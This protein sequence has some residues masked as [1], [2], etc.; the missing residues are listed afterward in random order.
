MGNFSLF[1]P[2]T[3]LTF[4]RETDS[5]CFNGEGFL[6]SRTMVICYCLPTDFRIALRKTCEMKLTFLLKRQKVVDF[7]I[8]LFLA[9]R[10]M[11]SANNF[12]T[13]FQF[14]SDERKLIAP[15]KRFC[16]IRNFFI[17]TFLLLNSIKVGEK[18]MN[19]GYY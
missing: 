18:I 11:Q 3:L 13:I 12:W 17:G 1:Y 2:S 7:D 15:R 6:F 16:S 19:K 4:W 14:H 5:F 8:V 10:Q 9:L